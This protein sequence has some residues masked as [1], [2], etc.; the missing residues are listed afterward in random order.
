MEKFLQCWLARKRETTCLVPVLIILQTKVFSWL[1]C[2]LIERSLSFANTSLGKADLGRGA[3]RM[4]K[5][6][7]LPMMEG[8]ST[9]RLI[10]A[11]HK[12]EGH[13]IRGAW[14]HRKPAFN[15]AGH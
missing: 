13:G 14:I 7:Q 9:G 12:K 4:W 8:R 10:K 5:P 15:I 1:P 3:R 11:R 6:F 2:D